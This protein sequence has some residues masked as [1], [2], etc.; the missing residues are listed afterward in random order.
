MGGG[1]SVANKE[2]LPKYLQTIR[3]GN[4]SKLVQTLVLVETLSGVNDNKAYLGAHDLGLIGEMC[5]I[6]G[7]DVGEARDLSLRIMYNISS[8]PANSLELM[9][10]S[11]GLPVLLSN[12]LKSGN[13]ATKVFTFNVLLNLGSN[14]KN[15]TKLLNPLHGLVPALVSVLEV[16]DKE[17]CK[18]SVSLLGVLLMSPE[19]ASVMGPAA[20][21]LLQPLAAI[22]S[23]RSGSLLAKST[24]LVRRIAETAVTEVRVRASAPQLGLLTALLQIIDH[25][26]ADIGNKT[27]ALKA[28]RFIL[29]VDASVENMLA[30]ETGLVRKIGDLVAIDGLSKAALG[31]LDGLLAVKAVACKR[32]LSDPGTGLPKT[33][34][35]VLG[36]KMSPLPRKVWAIKALRNL[37]G[38]EQNK[39]VFGA[40]TA[41]IIPLLV[42]YV[43]SRIPEILPDAIVCLSIFS[44]EESFVPQMIVPKLELMPALVT[45]I[46][47]DKGELRSLA[48][49]FF[50]NVAEIPA[51][52]DAMCSYQLGLMAVV[53][54]ILQ[55]NHG[56][57]V[58]LTLSMLHKVSKSEEDHVWFGTSD[59]GILPHLVMIAGSDKSDQ[60]ERKQE[61]KFAFL[62]IRNMSKT[63]SNRQF[64]ATPRIGLIPFLIE[65]CKGSSKKKS[66]L[67]LETL[68]NIAEDSGSLCE[69]FSN[70]EFYPFLIDIVR[71][72]ETPPD[73]W[74]AECVESICLSLLMHV[75]QWTQAHPP[76]RRAGDAV[77][78]LSRVAASDSGVQGM[79]AALTLGMLVGASENPRDEAALRESSVCVKVLNTV[80]VKQTRSSRNLTNVP[81]FPMKVTLRAM[82]F[83]SISDVNK[84]IILSSPKI[85]KDLA[86]A[87]RDFV[88]TPSANKF[89]HDYEISKRVAELLLDVLLSL[90][91]AFP[92]S[93]AL[94]AADA[95]PVP[96]LAKSLGGVQAT[97]LPPPSKHTAAMLAWRLADARVDEDEACVRNYI[98]VIFHQY[99]QADLMELMECFALSLKSMNYNIVLVING[100]CLHQP[101]LSDWDLP[102]ENAFPAAIL[103]RC[104]AVVVG[105]SSGL[106]DSP[107][108]RLMVQAALDL[109]R[110]EGLAV[111]FVNM[112]ADFSMERSDKKLGMKSC[113]SWLRSAIGNAKLPSLWTIA[114]VEPTSNKIGEAFDSIKELRGG[115]IPK[116][117]KKPIQYTKREAEGNER[118]Y[119]TAWGILQLANKT[120]NK[121]E[122]DSLI[123]SIG[124]YNA[125]DLQLCDFDD[126]MCMSKL[127][128][129]IQMRNFVELV[130]DVVPDGNSA[131]S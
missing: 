2:Q 73:K 4:T 116:K 67:A 59:Q 23:S 129:K 64:M 42:S 40:S 89:D 52:R 34:C 88:D 79:K 35:E 100:K 38:V 32:Y 121:D 12:I 110:N 51:T 118:R 43:R 92:T 53:T 56:E 113:S 115:S 74:A 101:G 45:L 6:L 112:D 130:F 86:G 44:L 3:K 114:N 82:W 16:A 123:A 111:E 122:L 126:L 9:D 20:A 1:A 83:L 98:A 95:F 28:I 69:A 36:N 103:A 24:S 17:L 65:R 85:I 46:N 109:R 30:V 107:S 39:K 62:I 84:P 26:T 33:I 90:T 93:A 57:A 48:L 37:L 60:P 77:P 29:A 58:F 72:S 131:K 104:S 119:A 31:V 66:E 76:L 8:V 120:N 125:M 14:Q 55:E 102:A 25:A 71:S 11:H 18:Y 50:I 22:L 117:K 54:S 99:V 106:N 105:L 10:T 124:V 108:C 97:D 19:G 96:D 21:L 75:T 91:L 94:L 127:L 7:R 87:L 61:K 13:H 5:D 47:T 15:A 27:T 63:P 128:K 80:F 68:A 70:Y 49:G 78:V 41:Q 81:K